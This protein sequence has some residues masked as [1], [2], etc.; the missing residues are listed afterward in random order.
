[1]APSDYVVWCCCIGVPLPGAVPLELAAAKSR[2]GHAETGAGAI[3]MRAAAMRLSCLG[4]LPFAHLRS[5]NVHVAQALDT[6]KAVQWFAPRESVGGFGGGSVACVSAFAF[7]GTNAHA[8]L[9][10]TALGTRE[11]GGMS[12]LL[13]KCS[14]N[15]LER[16][17]LHVLAM[18]VTATGP[19]GA[20]S[21]SGMRRS[22]M[23]CCSALCQQAVAQT[24]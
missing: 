18:Q 12:P 16:G 19:A 8:V 20:D 9:C 11:R 6:A 4:Q 10:R 22:Q 2:G 5:M 3:G 17:L 15:Y 23:G 1:M 7:Q 13:L 21:D 14:M 24:C